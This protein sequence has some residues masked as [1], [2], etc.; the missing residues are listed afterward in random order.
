M[1]ERTGQV[2]WTAEGILAIPQACLN[3]RILEYHS[4][5]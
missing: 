1:I 2:F 4:A 3:L 5:K